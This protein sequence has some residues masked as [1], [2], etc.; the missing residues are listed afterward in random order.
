MGTSDQEKRKIARQYFMRADQGRPDILELFHED[1]EVYFPNFGFG[2]SRDSFLEMVKGFEGALEYIQHDYD[3]F[4][5][6][7]SA[8]YLV[9]EGTSQRRMSGKPWAGAKLLAVVSATSSSFEKAECQACTS[10]LIQTIRERMRRGFDGARSVS[11][12]IS[13]ARGE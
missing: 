1:A 11:G 4:T 10:I 5:S 6:I 9:V 3:R 2:F 12:E 7:P 13:E 8:D